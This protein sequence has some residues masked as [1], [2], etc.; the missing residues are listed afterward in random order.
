MKPLHKKVIVLLLSASSFFSYAQTANYADK[1]NVIKKEFFAINTQLNSFKRI[2]KTDTIE[3]TEGNK[4]LKYFKG[5]KLKMLRAT[6]YG[7]TGKLV[8]E[9]YFDDNR[10]I[11]YYSVRS[12]YVAP[13]NVNSNG[14]IRSKEEARLY[15][16]NSNVLLANLSPKKD[17]SKNELK[18][19]GDHTRSEASRLERL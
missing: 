3:T 7:E 8:D 18:K 11:F 4:I 9:Y 2:E 19:L 12:Q 1:I 10:L 13:I 15:L 5:N 17:I 14:K 6:Y 16:D